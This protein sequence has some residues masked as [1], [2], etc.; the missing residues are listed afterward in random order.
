LFVYL[1]FVLFLFFFFSLFETRQQS[2]RFRVPAQ[3]EDIRTAVVASRAN[4]AGEEFKVCIAGFL[5]CCPY[6]ANGFE[7]AKV[8]NGLH[9]ELISIHVCSL[10]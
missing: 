10:P 5:P 8:T 7:F 9:G 1:S 4:Y 3:H 2:F 6:F